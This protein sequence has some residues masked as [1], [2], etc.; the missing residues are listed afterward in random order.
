MLQDY[1]IS[2]THCKDCGCELDKDKLKGNRCMKCHGKDMTRRKKAKRT[3]VV[4]AH[5]DRCAD[6]GKTFPHV[7]YDFHHEG[8]KTDCVSVMIGNNRKLETILE[9][10]AKCVM[11][12]ANCHRIRHF[13]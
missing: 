7:C 13:K 1:Q 6:C 2:L 12:C 8:D 10:A 4:E 5:G 9:E 3:A 11:L